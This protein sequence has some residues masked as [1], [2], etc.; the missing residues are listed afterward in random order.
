MSLFTHK[1]SLITK[2]FVSYQKKQK[3]ATIFGSLF[4][5]KIYAI[6]NSNCRQGEQFAPN[7][8]FDIYY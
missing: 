6:T 8:D 4:I 2:I 7:S 5:E 1:T 3:Q